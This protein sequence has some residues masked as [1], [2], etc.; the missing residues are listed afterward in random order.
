MILA[1]HDE[2]VAA[3]PRDQGI[4]RHLELQLVC[5]EA[6][7]LVAGHMAVD[8][9]DVLEMV[10]VDPEHRERCAGLQLPA[11]PPR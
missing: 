11:P 6:Q 10:E 8:V 2:F 7:D 9:V 4:G 5:D 3:E 1:Q